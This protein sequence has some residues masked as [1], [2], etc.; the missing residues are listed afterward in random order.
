MDQAEARKLAEAI[1]AEIARAA[2][3][4]PNAPAQ[5]SA[6]AEE[7]ERVFKVGDVVCLNSGGTPMTVCTVMCSPDVEV[8]WMH[9][10]VLNTEEIRK[11]CLRPWAEEIP[12]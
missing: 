4:I 11:V 7:A 5:M 3:L 10:G 2:G 9:Q 12:W 6:N 8:M 1:P